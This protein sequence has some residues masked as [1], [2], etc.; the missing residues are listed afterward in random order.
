MRSILA[1]VG[2]GLALLLC[3]GRTASAQQANDAPIRIGVS[4]DQSGTARDTG[5]S[6]TMGS[7]AYFQKINAAGGVFGHPLT[8]IQKD[9]GYDPERAVTNTWQL[10]EQEKV[11]FLFDYL[12]TPTLVRTLPLLKYY[13]S[14]RVVNVA[15]FSGAE[16]Q[17]T[18]P[19]DRYVFNIRASYNRET[20]ALVDYLVGKG[21]KHIGVFAQADAYGKSGELGVKEAL[22]HY[23]LSVAGVAT[24]RRLSLYNV[25]MKRQI[26][27]LRKAGADA[28]IAVSVYGAGA[29]LIRD[30]RQ[31]GWNVPIA[32]LSFVN[33]RALLDLL[34]SESATRKL[35]LTA[36]LINSEVVPSP[37]STEYPLVRDYR[38]HVPSDAYGTV[39]LEGWLNA[40]VVTEALRRAGPDAK[41][42]DFIR[43]LES[44]DGWD[45]GLGV[46]LEFSP[47]RHQGLDH[48]WLTRTQQGKWVEIHGDEPK[49]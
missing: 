17:R 33:S 22:R 9:D 31:A 29:A 6:L 25:D 16:P 8:L 45:P 1:H 30:A 10:V 2:I 32:N 7:S 4:S 14:A 11:F 3:L 36:N 20:A 13:E 39:S 34:R 42:M 48:V 41:R 49:P 28:V 23:G 5:V 47:T 40:V 24:Y 46:R 44:L 26:E 27:I 37:D 19:Y 12:G 38:A 15:P 18:A 35:D 43:A 21:F